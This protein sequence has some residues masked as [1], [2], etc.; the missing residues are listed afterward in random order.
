MTLD[1]VGPDATP[2]SQVIIQ[3]VR[4]SI[5]SY[6]RELQQLDREILD[7][8]SRKYFLIDPPFA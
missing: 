5:Y 1:P 8:C 4:N 7:A 3:D 6:G 2:A